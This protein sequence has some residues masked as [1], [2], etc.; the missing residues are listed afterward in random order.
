MQKLFRVVEAQVQDNAAAL[1][2]L[3]RAPWA[4]PMAEH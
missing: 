3:T 4:T 2:A 1:R